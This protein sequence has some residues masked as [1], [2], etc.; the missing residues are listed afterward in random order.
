V[1]AALTVLSPN[2]SLTCSSIAVNSSKP[3]TRELLEYVLARCKG[4]QGAT[5]LLG[6]RR[7]THNLSARQ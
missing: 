3:Q 6:S 1:R 5:D 2:K 7:L 4:D